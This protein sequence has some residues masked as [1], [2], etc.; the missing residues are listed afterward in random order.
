M[1]RANSDVFSGNYNKFFS[2]LLTRYARVIV[3]DSDG[4]ALSSLDH[5]FLLKFPP[6]VRIAAPQAYWLKGEGVTIGTPDDCP[7][8]PLVKVSQWN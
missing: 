8:K 3:L 2:F 6:G 5:L 4:F 1:H 7:G